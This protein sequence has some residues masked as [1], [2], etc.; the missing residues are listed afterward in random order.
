MSNSKVNFNN[1]TYRSDKSSIIVGEI[2]I[3]TPAPDSIEIPPICEDCTCHIV[4]QKGDDAKFR[5]SFLIAP[6]RA[7]DICLYDQCGHMFSSYTKTRV[8]N[9]HGTIKISADNKVLLSNIQLPA[10]SD[11]QIYLVI[12]V[13]SGL[14]QATIDS[15]K[16]YLVE[17]DLEA[18]SK[19]YDLSTIIVFMSS[20]IVN[21]LDK[22]GVEYRKYFK[23]VLSS[24]GNRM[25]EYICEYIAGR[26]VTGS[27]PTFQGMLTFGPE[28][29]VVLVRFCPT[30][31]FGNITAQ[32][33]RNGRIQINSEDSQ[34]SAYFFIMVKHETS[35]SLKFME[36]VTKKEFAI[37]DRTIEN[38]PDLTDDHFTVLIDSIRFL[39]KLNAN[40]ES[41]EFT[42]TI[43]DNSEE[44][45]KYLFN[46]PLGVFETIDTESTLSQIVVD[47]SRVV[48]HQINYLVQNKTVEHFNAIPRKLAKTVMFKDMDQNYFGCN[49][50]GG[51]GMRAVTSYTGNL[52]LTPALSSVAAPH[53]VLMQP[54]VSRGMCATSNDE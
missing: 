47:Y 12:N 3:N 16:K 8:N 1:I 43:L 11:G 14:T 10:V 22:L 32:L 53:P 38:L 51:H 23:A 29:E 5:S 13:Y 17:K 7:N 49:N 21:E 25:S 2:I 48:R 37:V 19:K 46:T 54:S 6:V 44:V 18:F 30:K 39:E 27:R 24:S 34:A 36:N 26:T 31:E 35:D 42:Q 20:E 15:S 4:L 50:R 45:V 9:A 41:K 33:R 52:D 28:T 40:R